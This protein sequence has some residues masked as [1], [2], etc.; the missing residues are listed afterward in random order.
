MF[1]LCPIVV[2]CRYAYQS[3]ELLFTWY[4]HSPLRV[5]HG[6]RVDSRARKRTAEEMNGPPQE[7]NSKRLHSSQEVS[8][9][10]RAKQ[11]PAACPSNVN[12]AVP[13]TVPSA[14]PLDPSSSQPSL[15]EATGQGVVPSLSQTEGA[16]GMKKIN[17]S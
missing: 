5:D 16:T 13:Q 14:T 6:D 10:I 12:P 4:L 17:K 8:D 3:V 7:W 11:A 1:F 9:N 2:L 15:A